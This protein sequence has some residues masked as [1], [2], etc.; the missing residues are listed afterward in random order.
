MIMVTQEMCGFN[1]EKMLEGLPA[2]ATHLWPWFSPAE[3]CH[4]TPSVL[5][6]SIATSVK[7]NENVRNQNA[8][9]L[10]PLY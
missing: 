2:S 6:G 1:N 3:S 8:N 4:S 10:T 7:Q 5:N 9:T